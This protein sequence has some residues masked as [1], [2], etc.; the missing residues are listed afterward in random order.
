MQIV[1]HNMEVGVKGK[2]MRIIIVLKYWEH[3]ENFILATSSVAEQLVKS[4][5][6]L[7]SH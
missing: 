1:T 7:F 3:Y 5:V 4:Y 2:T 6:L